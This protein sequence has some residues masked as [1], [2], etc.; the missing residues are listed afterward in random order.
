MRIFGEFGQEFEILESGSTTL[1]GQAAQRAIL[2]YQA[3]SESSYEN[4]LIVAV[5]G[6]NSYVINFVATPSEFDSLMPS[7][8]RI[9]DSFEFIGLSG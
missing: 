4:L 1:G 5:V 6:N 8:Q 9:I 7:V 2:S 3:L